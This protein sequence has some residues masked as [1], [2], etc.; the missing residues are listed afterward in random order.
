[1]S[2]ENMLK[3]IEWVNSYTHLQTNLL[4]AIV[5]MLGVIAIGIFLC[6]FM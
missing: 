6:A 2:T 5:V 4:N 1:M 3:L